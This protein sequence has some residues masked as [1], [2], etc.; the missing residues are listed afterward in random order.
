M[1]DKGGAV[2]LVIFG[3]NKGNWWMTEDAL[4]GTRVRAFA[5][6]IQRDPEVA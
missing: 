2:P 1:E 4:V 6:H 3:F 5:D